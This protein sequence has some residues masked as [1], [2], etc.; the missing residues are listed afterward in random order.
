MRAQLIMTAIL[1]TFFISCRHQAIRST[2]LRDIE[3]PGI[4]GAPA[5]V[6]FEDKGKVHVR[7]C[8]Q[9]VAVP[10]G[11]VLTRE[12]CSVDLGLAPLAVATYRDRLG[13]ALGVRSADSIAK[14]EAEVEQADF[15]LARLQG[16]QLDIRL[17]GRIDDASLIPEIN[18]AEGRS[19][20]LRARL[21]TARSRNEQFDRI[22]AN[23]KSSSSIRLY[24]PGI[25]QKAALAP[26]DEP[27]QRVNIISPGSCVKRNEIGMVFC[28]IPAGKFVM[29]APPAD[30]TRARNTE[31]Q[32]QHEVTISSDFEMMATE[33]TQAMWVAVMG[34]NPS[35]FN[36]PGNPVERVTFDEVVKEFMPR[37][38]ARLV[39][40]NYRYRLPTEA[41]WEYACRAGKGGDFGIDG[42]PRQFS[43]TLFNSERESSRVGQLKANAFGLFDMHGNVRELVLDA[44][45]PYGPE[46]VTDPLVTSGD[47]QIWRGGGWRDMDSMS[48]CA[49]RGL[50][51]PGQKDDSLGFRLVRVRQ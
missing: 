39:S 25:D 30:A 2:P 11:G 21:V 32:P 8:A 34:Q 35:Q 1:A 45:T 47:G 15:E 24:G 28:D 33:V 36:A 14:S 10:V 43:W 49:T 17:G 46:A 44:F 3:V 41:E 31:E 40:D 51:V 37:L 13:K 16:R 9:G 7:G 26:F 22:M 4:D 5:R 48:R 50:V 19:L 6:V 20:E 23:L 27:A 42:D 29:G 12:V 38:N 18:R